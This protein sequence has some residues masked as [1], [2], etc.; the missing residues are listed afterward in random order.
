MTSPEDQAARAVEPSSGTAA[1]VEQARDLA[2]RS[3]RRAA[4]HAGQWVE[5]ASTPA[6]VLVTA[7]RGEGHTE[8]LRHLP[9]QG[10]VIVA[11]N[12][13]HALDARA[14]VAA[15]PRPALVISTNDLES[16]IRLRRAGRKPRRGDAWQ[17]ALDELDRGGVVAV[18]PEG[19]P[20]PD[21]N[22]HKGRDGFGR[23]VLAAGA[24]VVP[25][26][27]TTRSAL[28]VLGPA[29]EFGRFDDLPAD[30][31]LAR[32]VTDEVMGAIADLGRLRYL[33]T[34]PT[35]ARDQLR[36]AAQK[37]RDQLRALAQTRR[38]AEQQAIEARQVADLEER[39][40]L[41]RLHREAEEQARTRAEQA[42]QRDW[43]RRAL[44]VSGQTEQ[45]VDGNDS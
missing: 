39:R 16:A 12:H 30:R 20:S 44:Q 41:A 28:L 5:R 21:T 1:F 9:Q 33:D 6:R 23:L 27:L 10:P 14:L 8:G 15:L 32:G 38:L 34:Y 36:S 31:T 2:V 22:L 24:P 37:R 13:R 25:A 17:A 3:G 7:L 40:D 26:V 11:V 19:A 4:E 45:D 18:F 43:Q 42:A 29:R 35:T